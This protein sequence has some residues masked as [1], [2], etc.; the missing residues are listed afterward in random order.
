MEG[1]R[2]T[3]GGDHTRLGVGLP[4][5]LLTACKFQFS[6]YLMAGAEGSVTTEMK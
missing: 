4:L 2:G 5:P 6:V 1:A 3:D